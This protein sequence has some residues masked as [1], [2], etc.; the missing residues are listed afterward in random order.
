MKIFVDCD[1]LLDVGLGR[2]PFCQASGA[3]LNYLENNK[4][5]GFIAWHSI[6]NFFY[7]TAKGNN[8]QQSKNFIAELCAFLEIV[9]VSNQDLT[10][11]LELPINDFEDTMQCASAM[12]CHADVIISRNIRDFQYSPIKAMSPEQFLQELNGL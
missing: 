8:K 2:E 6:A 7:L 9:A 11:A 10:V 5:T 1:V 4:N 3:L 12:A